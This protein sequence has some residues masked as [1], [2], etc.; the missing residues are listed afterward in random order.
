M[1]T[2]G[3]ILFIRGWG[4]AAMGLLLT[5]YGFSVWDGEEVLDMDGGDGCTPVC[6][7]LVSLN[8]TLKMGNGMLCIFYHN[9]KSA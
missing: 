1:E 5:K 6:V 3:R 2:E 7:H 4:E 9:N 8:Y